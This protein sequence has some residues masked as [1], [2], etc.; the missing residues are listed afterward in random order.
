MGCL[1]YSSYTV[2]MLADQRRHDVR[3]SEG[4]MDLGPPTLPR[5]SCSLTAA[6]DSKA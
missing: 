1:R 6:W 4:Q 3:A 5:S 2:Q